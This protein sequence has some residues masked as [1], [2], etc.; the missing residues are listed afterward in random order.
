MAY[1]WF[2]KTSGSNLRYELKDQ[3]RVSPETLD[4]DEPNL[5]S[6]AMPLLGLNLDPSQLGA[7]CI[8]QVDHQAHNPRTWP[9]SGTA[10]TA[11]VAGDSTIAFDSPYMLFTSS[12][13]RTYDEVHFEK[14]VSAFD[15]VED[16][17]RP[18]LELGNAYRH[19][20][21][22]LGMVS[23]RT[24]SGA[25]RP[26]GS[27]DFYNVSRSDTDVGRAQGH[28]DINPMLAG[29]NLSPRIPSKAFLGQ[30]A[31]PSSQAS[32]VEASRPD[33]QNATVLG[34]SDATQY[35]RE[36]ARSRQVQG[37]NENPTEPSKRKKRKLSPAGKEHAKAVRRIGACERCRKKKTKAGAPSQRFR[38]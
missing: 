34:N 35:G 5:P 16:Q 37:Q 11:L 17:R 14:G 12:K 1:G 33:F 30:P 8:A 31:G 36:S 18:S 32:S 9:S 13:R 19:N 29:P 20:N 4:Y 2:P 10:Q 6:M 27:F 15:Y 38:W 21:V 23:I 28:F 22:P 3:G 7:G 25:S 26:V 24:R